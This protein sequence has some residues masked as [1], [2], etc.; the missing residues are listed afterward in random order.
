[1][2]G[3]VARLAAA[4]STELTYA[5]AAVAAVRATH[6]FDAAWAV[7]AVWATHRFRRRLVAVS[8]STYS[9]KDVLVAM[10]TDD[11]MSKVKIFPTFPN[12]S[13]V[14]AKIT[15]QAGGLVDHSACAVVSVAEQLSAHPTRPGEAFAVLKENIRKWNVYSGS[16][17]VYL[18]ENEESISKGMIIGICTECGAGMFPLSF[19]N[20][21]EVLE[22]QTAGWSALHVVVTTRHENI[23]DGS[24]TVTAKLFHTA[25]HGGIAFGEKLPGGDANALP[26]RA[27]GDIEIYY[28]KR[29]NLTGLVQLAAGAHVP[30]NRL[31][32]ARGC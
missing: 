16:T 28:T 23:V 22:L 27:A 17:K 19:E 31:K 9:F 12:V 13:D 8:D 1:M 3:A 14:Q 10:F 4:Y 29:Q 25:G 30:S 24:Y 2:L 15:T 7:V 26:V 20:V 5:A 11:L 21:T 32:C 18:P 6:R